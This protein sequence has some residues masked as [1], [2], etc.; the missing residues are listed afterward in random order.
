MDLGKTTQVVLTL[1]GPSSTDLPIQIV[2]FYDHSATTTNIVSVQTITEESI[3]AAPYPV[4]HIPV[5]TVP[6]SILADTIKKD[7]GL[8]TVITQITKSSQWQGATV[9]TVEVHTLDEKTVQYNVVMELKGQKHQL[10]QVYD[11]PTSKITSIVVAQLSEE[12][13][14]VLHTQTTI[15]HQEVI[16]SNRVESVRQQYP[17]TTTTIDAFL[18]DNPAITVNKID[19]IVVAPSSE[20]STISILAKN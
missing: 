15:D 4:P 12:V 17:Q 10:V 2:A 14:S 19:S 6:A 9:S 5:T 11:K 13:K 1:E 3:S 20:G 8:K 7:T 18:L 16:I